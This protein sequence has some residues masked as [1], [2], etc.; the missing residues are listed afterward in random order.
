MGTGVGDAPDATA[1]GGSL[2]FK[3]TAGDVRA[4]V[5]EVV[6]TMLE[7]FATA[8]GADNAEQVPAFTVLRALSDYLKVHSVD[9]T[10]WVVVTVFTDS[11]N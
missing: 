2:C 4:T 8:G 10:E 11:S 7:L 5:P 3:L 1:A 6:V 9:V